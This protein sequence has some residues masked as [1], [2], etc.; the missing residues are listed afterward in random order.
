MTAQGDTANVA[1]QETDYLSS[2]MTDQL[3]RVRVR[4]KKLAGDGT[5]NP[6]GWLWDGKAS[7]I[8][9]EVAAPTSRL[10]GLGEASISNQ[11]GCS[12]LAFS[13]DGHLMIVYQSDK[14]LQSENLLA[15]S[16]SR[17]LG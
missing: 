10:K 11:L 13:S 15:P 4:S 16:G 5:P 8:E 14:N 17:S 12:T 6:V 2:L 9:E 3:A 1:I 7:F